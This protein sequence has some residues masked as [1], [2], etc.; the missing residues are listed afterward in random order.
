MPTA[1]M[2]STLHGVPNPTGTHGMATRTMSARCISLTCS[3][4]V[5][6]TAFGLYLHRP[7]S[8]NEIKKTLCEHPHR[9]AQCCPQGSV[10]LATPH[11]D[12]GKSTEL[13]LVLITVFSTRSPI[14]LPRHRGLSTKLNLRKQLAYVHRRVGEVHKQDA[15]ASQLPHRT[16]PLLTLCYQ[17]S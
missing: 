16:M 14:L 6:C 8:R 2:V 12:P 5:G 15:L 4:A 3:S 7:G 13:R 9:F 10:K 1:C 11:P 17:T